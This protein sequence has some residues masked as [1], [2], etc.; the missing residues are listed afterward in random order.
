MIPVHKKQEYGSPL[1]KGWEDPVPDPMACNGIENIVDNIGPTATVDTIL[2]P[3]YN[4]K[5]SDEE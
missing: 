5:V 2:K 3:I 1:C 4:F